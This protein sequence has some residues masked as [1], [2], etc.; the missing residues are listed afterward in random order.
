MEALAQGG[1]EA[2]KGVNLQTE[3]DVDQFYKEKQTPHMAGT[4]AAG[5][6]PYDAAEA[7]PERLEIGLPVAVGGA[8]NW[9]MV[10][11]ILK[12]LQ[13][14]PPVKQVRQ[15]IQPIK[16]ESMPPFSGE[17]LAAFGDDLAKT[18]LREA[19]REAIKLLSDEKM[20]QEFLEYY[21]GGDSAEIKNRI[22]DQQKGPAKVAF[23]LKEALDDLEKVGKER[24]KEPSKRWQ[25]HYD[26]V[27]ARLQERIAYVH[28]YDSALGQ[29]RKDALPKRD[30]AI[31][32]GWRLASQEKLQ[33]TEAR[34][35]AAEAR[36]GLTKV[37]KA[38]KGTP[39][40]ILAKRELLTTLGLEWKPT[41]GY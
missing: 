25:A 38:Y 1:D 21:G 16:P 34:K 27:L 13:G 15:G 31:H 32:T 9:D 36:K 8:A 35:M 4:E 3:R 12:D 5:G 6:A 39:W 29:I 26:Y 20:N 17:K 37:A 18:P 10:A 2:D 28:E 22:L 19:V 14:I 33:N 41:R 23:L 7:L 24:D 40:E 11:S 30:P